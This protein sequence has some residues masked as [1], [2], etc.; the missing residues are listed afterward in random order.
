M[1]LS[2]PAK[3]SP[4][5]DVLYPLPKLQGKVTQQLPGLQWEAWPLWHSALLAAQGPLCTTKLRK[6]TGV[7]YLK[8]K[9]KYYSSL[10]L[11]KGKTYHWLFLQVEGAG[12]LCPG[13]LVPLLDRG[14]P[15]N[16]SLTCGVK[17]LFRW[18]PGIGKSWKTA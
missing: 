7:C 16:G 12:S 9:R 11:T 15:V 3:Q 4:R 13:W 1:K 10:S 5:L 17:V 8:G 18:K 2:F 14:V 6:V